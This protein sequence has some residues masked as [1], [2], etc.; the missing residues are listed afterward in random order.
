M[1]FLA[2]GALEKTL[3]RV[4]WDGL[5]PEP[6]LHL[7]GPERGASRCIVGNHPGGP[8]DAAE[9]TTPGAVGRRGTVLK[10]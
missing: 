7:S 2:F 10:V 9:F 5:S 1:V 8:G 4:I 6:F 3:S